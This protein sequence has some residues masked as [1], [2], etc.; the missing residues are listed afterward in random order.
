MIGLESR[1]R[2]WGRVVRDAGPGAK[3]C[4]SLEAG[5]RSPQVWD[6]PVHATNLPLTGADMADGW[7]VETAWAT[8]GRLNRAI[9]RSHYCWR[10]HY[11]A[12][13]L[14]A[15]RR[16][17]TTHYNGTLDLAHA[18]MLSALQRP[19]DQN[20]NIV[21]QFVKTTLAVVVA[22]DYNELT[23]QSA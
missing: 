13:A 1:L 8:L 15:S 11:A 5:W 18:A 19:I 17:G 16:L 9:L 12:A 22:V 4:G 6:E 20:R 2:N 14:R 7:A 3:S 23:A 10:S 21:H